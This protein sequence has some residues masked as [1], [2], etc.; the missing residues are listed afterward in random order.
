MTHQKILSVSTRAKSFTEI[1]AQVQ[2]IV[3]AS[4]VKTGLCN[5]FIQH[6]SASLLI[7]ENADP[8][9]RRDLENYFSDLVPE[10]RNYIHDA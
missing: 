9:V 7:T 10:S 1:T 6:T 5:V 2:E 4:N 8:D 3:S